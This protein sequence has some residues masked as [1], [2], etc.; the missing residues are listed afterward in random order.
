MTTD[1]Q[2]LPRPLQTGLLSGHGQVT[3]PQMALSQYELYAENAVI[4]FSL[5]LPAYHST[6]VLHPLQMEHPQ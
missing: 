6:A 5:S 4:P 1:T 2:A 3:A